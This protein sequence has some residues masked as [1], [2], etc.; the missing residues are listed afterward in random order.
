MNEINHIPDTPARKA[1]ID[2]AGSFIVQAPAGS[3]KTGLLIQ[4]YLALLPCVTSPEEVL[5]ITFTK[6]A[7][8]EM[9][10]RIISAL[11]QAQNP[12][13]P[14]TAHEKTTWGL[15]RAALATDEKSGWAIDKNPSRLRV[16]TIDALCSSLTRQMPFLAG[17]GGQ[18]EIAENPGALYAEAASNTVSE[19]ETGSA[20]A[21]DIAIL[22]KN[23]DNR[24]D[25]VE[26]LVAAMLPRRDQ[27]LRHVVD[28]AGSEQYRE[29]LESAMR[30]VISDTLRSAGKE[31]ASPGLPPPAEWMPVA[32]F[33][34]KNLLSEG[35]DSPICNCHDLAVLPGDS[36][37]D[38]PAWQGISELFLTQKGEW[39]KPG[40]VSKRI[41]F[42]PKSAGLDPETKATNESMKNAFK[43]CL[44]EF[45]ANLAVAQVLDMIRS[46]PAPGYTDEQWKVMAALFTTLKLAAAHL[47][48]VFAEKNKAD[49]TEMSMRA[50]MALGTPDNPTDLALRLDYAISHILI[51][52]FQDTSISQFEL[53]K[54]LTA[55][56][57][58]GDK[59][60]FFAVG[61]PMQSIYAFREAEVGIF[62]NT[63][64]NGLGHIP[65]TSLTLSTNFRSE[66]GI[67]DWINKTFPK[68]FPKSAGGAEGAVPYTPCAAVHSMGPGIAVHVHALADTGMDNE[69]AIV[70]DCVESIKKNRPDDRIAILVRGR[71]HLREIIPTLRARGI[72]FSA[73]DIDPLET[74][75]VIRD[76]ISL[77]R[78]LA[79]PADR[80]AWLAI[81][82][83]PWCGLRLEDLHILAGDDHS[84]AVHELIHEK[85]RLERLCA[86]SA[87]RLL[88]FRQ[89]IDAAI[90][91][92]GRRSLSRMVEITW[93]KLG[94]QATMMSESDIKEVRAYLDLLE[95]VT[96]T[97]TLSDYN[98]FNSAV[99]G[100]FALPDPLADGSIRIMTIHKAKGLEFDIVLIPGLEKSAP[101]EVDRLL[102]WLERPDVPG[103]EGLLMA[104][105]GETGRQ[106]DPTYKYIKGLH[107]KKKGLEVG[108]ILYVA[109]TRAKRELHLFGR[110]NLT[111]D[112]FVKTPKNGSFLNMLWPAVEQDFTKAAQITTKN[113]AGPEPGTGINPKFGTTTEILEIQRLPDQWEAPA[114]G[115]GILIKQDKSP[116]VSDASLDPGLDGPP[117]FDWAG[118]TARRVGIV[119]H[120]WLRLI[121][122][123]GID[124]WNPDRVKMAS[125]LIR[126]DMERSGV[127]PEHI[128]SAANLAQT[129]LTNTLTDSRGK[130][131]LSPHESSACEY[132]LSGIDGN[133]IINAV[134]DRSFVDEEGVVRII[135]YKTSTHAGGDK[136]EFLDREQ[137]RYAGVMNRYARLMHAMTG[138]DVKLGLYYPLLCGWRQWKI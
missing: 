13:P 127:N 100:L 73:M 67:V 27:W 5:A 71:P 38:L 16:M 41:G 7:A 18:P 21:D 136:E 4:R 98:Q 91:N 45:S 102:F 121:C 110:I 15:A 62:L 3:G 112:G 48:L 58:L 14:G 72:R 49:F 132:A 113:D 116:A 92:T 64:E 25:R 20:R 6:K 101:G 111:E 83:A 44:E 78:A 95:Q 76:L 74:R 30:R 32:R 59:R 122:E 55:G 46:I 37:P 84:R 8:A 90:K 33:A 80:I 34:A 88:S 94:G 12:D 61:D 39:R 119:V 126:V 79:H 2:P 131:I 28:T 117:L 51:D 60:T 24:L 10:A 99:S 108:R 123:Q 134:I 103:E 63:W 36:L 96:G 124:K 19:L 56:W 9:R 118:F 47:S 120:R 97:G 54:Q 57:T 29:A 87:K 65:L 82:R 11:K 104:P 31:L 114:P 77:T 128:D 115:P 107:Q 106:N 40:G 22:V 23:T 81:L 53:L 66:K 129:A 135:D 69:A 105:M 109:A 125:R 68:V 138:R 86:N 42:P 70:A 17:F 85:S 52:E 137:D 43:S 89:I 26:A 1:A 130:W 93:R 50:A 35:I 133:E 75:P